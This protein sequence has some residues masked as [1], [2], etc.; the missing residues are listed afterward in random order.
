MITVTRRKDVQINT[1]LNYNLLDILTI[2]EKSVN[3]C[4][5]LPLFNALYHNLKLSQ[6]NK[7]SVEIS[8]KIKYNVLS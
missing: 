5:F 8:G 4:I 1:Y 3:I 7:K 2:Y 6:T